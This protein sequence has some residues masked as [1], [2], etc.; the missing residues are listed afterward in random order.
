[1]EN[2]P[3][4]VRDHLY[5]ALIT[6]FGGTNKNWPL[7]GESSYYTPRIINI[8]EDMTDLTEDQ[9]NSIKEALSNEYMMRVD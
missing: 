7:N 8:V 1:M 9:K 5:K 4:E 6:I 2:Y 3:E